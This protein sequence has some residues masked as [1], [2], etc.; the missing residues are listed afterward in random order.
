[1]VD[2]WFGFPMV[3]VDVVGRWVG[4]LSLP[5]FQVSSPDFFLSTTVIYTEL[6]S[7]MI[8]FHPSHTLQCTSTHVL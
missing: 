8:Y 3:G 5:L 2:S 4:W 7:P 6:T 1:M